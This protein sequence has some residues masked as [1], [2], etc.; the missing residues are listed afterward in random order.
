MVKKSPFLKKSTEYTKSLIRFVIVSFLVLALLVLI[1]LL[2]FDVISLNAA[3]VNALFALFGLLLPHEKSSFE[4]LFDSSP[5]ETYLS[6][7]FRKG[8]VKRDEL[9]RISYGTHYLIEV[10][11]EY[12]LLKNTNGIGLF[13]LPAR[14]YALPYEEAKELELKFGVIRDDYISDKNDYRMLVPARNLKHF[15]KYFCLH[16][17]PY[18]FPNKQM[19]IRYIADR[20]ALSEDLFSDSKIIFKK[21]IINNIAFSSY[22]G[23]Y[24]MLVFDVCVFV[25]NEAQLEAFRA[26]RGNQNENY[27]F[28]GVEL[29][30]NNGTDKAHNKL[31]ADIAPYIYSCIAN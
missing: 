28:A 3:L 29:I 26:I 27:K 8:V 31:H 18:A 30:K 19:I 4:K 14:T 12:L 2:I 25:P 17:D 24:E 10:D 11:G 21:R 6:L 23:H 16:V 5:W 20:C 1:A 22:T 15:Y 13:N 9:I 7:L